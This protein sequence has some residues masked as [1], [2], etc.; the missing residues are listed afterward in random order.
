MRSYAF[1][2]KKKRDCGLFRYIRI[3]VKNN[4]ERYLVFDEDWQGHPMVTRPGAHYSVQPSL[5]AQNLESSGVLMTL[6][7]KHSLSLFFFLKRRLLVRQKPRAGD[8][9]ARR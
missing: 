7:P 2:R 8:V 3:P 5:Q 4:L 9:P 1:E 6:V